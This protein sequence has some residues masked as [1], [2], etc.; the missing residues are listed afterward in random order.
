MSNLAL[1]NVN[2]C[3]GRGAYEVPEYPTAQSF[4]EHLDYLE[5]DRSLVW[6]VVARDLHPLTGNQRLLR[7]IE[8]AGLQERL[9][10]AFVITPA[11][12]YER[13]VLDYLRLQL[14]CG[15]VRALRISPKTSRFPIREIER[16]LGELARFEPVLFWDCRE[17]YGA[18]DLRDL[19]S[20]AQALPK[21]NFVLTQKMWGGFSGVLDLLWRCPNTS[22]DISWLHMRDTLELLTERFGAE[23]VLFGIGP[24]AHYGAA[25]AALAH[26]DLTSFQRELIAHG[27][28]ERLLK[29]EPLSG[30]LTRPPAQLAQK[31]LWQAFRS[32]QPVTGVDVIDAHGHTPPHT[33][34][35]VMRNQDT[36]TA[37]EAF[38]RR[39]DRLGV[40][41]LILSSEAALFGE[42]LAGNLETEK[43]LM[44]YRERLA[45]YLVFNPLYGE[46]M[47]PHLDDFFKRG[48]YVGFKLLASYW[49]CPV[50][51]AGYRPVWEFA[52]RHALPIL[53]HTWNDRHDSPAMLDE[54][55]A[56]YP[57]AVF[58]LGHSGGGS[59]GRLEA[60]ALALK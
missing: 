29:I 38:I 44:P 39:M 41:Q 49:K 21:V 58:L 30:K 20:L 4:V 40:K 57:R 25:I 55:V 28:L 42:N 13:G 17:S 26:A 23:R 11:C 16:V 33:R 47:T 56:R 1:F 32:G 2:G 46:E 12:F 27:N 54:I 10:P 36:A 24:R 22:V 53:L 6:H 5:I 48:F 51:D 31:P 14:A 7:E 35:W 34:G 19:E 18:H 43:Q 52:D 45:G 59:P 9:L 3:I 37:P 50:T 8:E 60:E 15:R